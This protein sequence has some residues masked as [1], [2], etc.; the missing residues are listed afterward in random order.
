MISNKQLNLL[1]AWQ[2][3]LSAEL[4][5]S[6][7]MELTHKKTK[8]WVFNTL[9]KLTKLNIIS[10]KKKANINLYS[11]N[12][13]S[14]ALLGAL[15]NLEM[16][17]TLI[18]PEIKLIDNLINEIPKINYCLMVFGSYADNKQ[19]ANSDLDICF[20]IENEA[21]GKNIKPYVNDIKLNYSTKIDDH[22]ITFNDFL[23]ML[24]N[25]EENL[26]KQIFRKHLILLNS[27]IFYLLLNKAH[28]NG[29]RA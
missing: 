16:Q 7:I 17:K 26:G 25:N 23:K 8:T 11:L 10:M 21:E 24:L 5:I 2:K 3:Q 12:L 15:H 27:D 19:K 4:S 9:N 13:S 28:K 29:F 22:Y 1:N 18:F 6:E 14:P 20:L